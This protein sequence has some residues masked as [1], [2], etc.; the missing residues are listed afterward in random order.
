MCSAFIDQTPESL[1][2]HSQNET[3]ATGIT[4]Y[5]VLRRRHHSSSHTQKPDIT[6]GQNDG[7]ADAAVD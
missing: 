1:G 7:T 2:R 5:G 6:L 3:N 4:S